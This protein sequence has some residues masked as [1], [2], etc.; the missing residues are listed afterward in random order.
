V[1]R[2]YEALAA[3]VWRWITQRRKD[4]EESVEA[5]VGILADVRPQELTRRPPVIS[6]ISGHPL[7]N[8]LREDGTAGDPQRGDETEKEGGMIAGM[9]SWV[10]MAAAQPH[11]TDW[12]GVVQ[13]IGLY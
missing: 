1:A 9:I 3:E 11:S 10:T 12:V 7:G 6:S 13:D 4:S 8:P 2:D 5:G